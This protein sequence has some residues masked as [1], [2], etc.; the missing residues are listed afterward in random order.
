MNIA[1]IAPIAARLAHLKATVTMEQMG[2]LPIMPFACLSAGLITQGHAQG[3]SA[4][5]FL[6]S[7]LERVTGVVW[8]RSLWQ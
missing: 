7:G 8:A 2:I 4:S 5:T 3:T 1:A 6:P